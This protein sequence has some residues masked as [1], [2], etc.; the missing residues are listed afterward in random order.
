P[1]RTSTLQQEAAKQLGYSAAVTMRLAQQLYEGIEI[2]AEGPVGLITYMRTDS[3]RVADSAV[4]QARAFIAREFDKGYLPATPNVHKTGKGQSKVQ[5]ELEAI[6]P[7]DVLR[8]PDDVKQHLDAK[9][10][11]RQP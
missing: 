7:I 11:P 6:R 2:G 5:D 10:S 8:P 1:F 4:A 3:I 9:Q